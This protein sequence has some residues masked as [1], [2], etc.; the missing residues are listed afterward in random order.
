MQAFFWVRN[1]T[2]VDTVFA[3]DPAHMK[4]PGEDS[5]GFRAISQRSMLA[6]S[7]KD[8]GAVTMSRL[9]LRNGSGK[10]RRRVFGR[11]FRPRTFPGCMPPMG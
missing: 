8:S 7:V 11:I 10:Y 5:N 4:I 1:N 9:W 2:P 3:L 6:D